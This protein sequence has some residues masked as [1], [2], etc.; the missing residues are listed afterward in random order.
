MVDPRLISLLGPV[1]WGKTLGEVVYDRVHAKG[2]HF[3][4]WE[5]PETIVKDLEGMFGK[6]GRCEGIVQGRGGYKK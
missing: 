4:A 6:G 2:G 3:A 5:V 1:I